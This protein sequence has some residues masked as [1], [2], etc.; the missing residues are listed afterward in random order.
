MG[1]Q[2]GKYVQKHGLNMTHDAIMVSSTS[3]RPLSVILMEQGEQ[4]WSNSLNA[5]MV[6]E[7]LAVL[8]SYITQNADSDAPEQV[9][10]WSEFE[11][12]AR[13][14]S[15][16]LWQHGNAAGALEDDEDY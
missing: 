12:E 5:Y 2:A 9:V 11:E 14:N 3:N 13:T 10:A 7:G 15:V 16:G 1:Q 8:Q 4:D 6:A